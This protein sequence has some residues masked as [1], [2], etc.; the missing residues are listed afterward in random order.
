M[1]LAALQCLLLFQATKHYHK[2]K[3]L[4]SLRYDRAKQRV[5]VAV[6]KCIELERTNPQGMKQKMCTSELK[7]YIKSVIK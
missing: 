7:L 5:F 1:S 4:I 6:F 2:G 3:A